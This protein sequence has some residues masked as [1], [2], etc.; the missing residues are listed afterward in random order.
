MAE[1][2]SEKTVGN[3]LIIQADSNPSLPNGL[4]AP[5]GSLATVLGVGDLWQKTGPDPVDWSIILAG[6]GTPSSIGS[7]NSEGVAD[8]AARSDHVHSHADQA[9]GSLHALA[10]SSDAGFLS[11]SDKDKLD[12]IHVLKA[13]ANQ[14]LATAFAGNPKKASVVFTTPLPSS[15][16]SITISSADTRVWTFEARTAAGFTINS[17]SAQALTGEVHWQAIED[18]QG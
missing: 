8:L 18:Y 5:M 15:A 1:T 2:I 7:S 11:A 9:G 13:Y 6:T 3:I 16:Y 12:S 14:V 17:N 4:D 10:T